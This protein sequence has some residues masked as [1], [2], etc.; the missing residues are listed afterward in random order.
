MRARVEKVD[1]LVWNK[2]STNIPRGLWQLGGQPPWSPEKLS[3][4]NPTSESGPPSGKPTKELTPETDYDALSEISM[5]TREGSMGNLFPWDIIRYQKGPDP[6]IFSTLEEPNKEASWRDTWKIRIWGQDKILEAG[7]D[8]LTLTKNP[9]QI[10]TKLDK[11]DK[12][13]IGA[14]I[15]MEGMSNL[16]SIE[17]FFLCYKKDL[18]F[19]TTVWTI[20]LT[21]T[22]SEYPRGV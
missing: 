13:A 12:N 7:E 6:P 4:W 19:G 18:F 2:S 9:S 20:S 15:T 10:P 8:L 3:F 17:Y 22:Y 14:D 21:T 11:V 5:P 16:C 1:V